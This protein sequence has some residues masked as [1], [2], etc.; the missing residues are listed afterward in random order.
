MTRESTVREDDGDW[1]IEI[2]VCK[3]MYMV[4]L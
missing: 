2:D 4:G 1:V 3:R